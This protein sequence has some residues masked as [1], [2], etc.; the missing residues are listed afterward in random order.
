MH[1]AAVADGSGFNAQAAPAAADDAGANA[2]ENERC[3]P[4][5]PNLTGMGR[6]ASRCAS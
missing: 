2:A 1:A 5:L 4:I 6:A 3:V